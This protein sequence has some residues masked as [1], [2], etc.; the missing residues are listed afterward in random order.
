MSNILCRTNNDGIFVGRRLKSAGRRWSVRDTNTIAP[1]RCADKNGEEDT[2]F[3]RTR[4]TGIKE[5][6]RT[7]N[8]EPMPIQPSLMLDPA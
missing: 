7:R 8:P 6:D 2:Y 3:E 4:M 5:L 1:L